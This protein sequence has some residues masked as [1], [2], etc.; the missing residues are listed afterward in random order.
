MTGRCGTGVNCAFYRALLRA[1]RGKTMT[2]GYRMV[3][4][5][6]AEVRGVVCM[7]SSGGNIWCGRTVS[8]FF[9]YFSSSEFGLRGI[10]GSPGDL[11]GW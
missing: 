1:D 10:A 9:E 4:H 3:A 2:S 8:V 11:C 5:K 7:P 6:P